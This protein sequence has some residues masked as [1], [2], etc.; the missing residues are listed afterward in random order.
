MQNNCKTTFYF[1]KRRLYLILLNP[2]WLAL[3]YVYG[4]LCVEI[5]FNLSQLG[6]KFRNT[7]A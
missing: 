5:T 4:L 7:L 1:K 3:G 2:V 6:A